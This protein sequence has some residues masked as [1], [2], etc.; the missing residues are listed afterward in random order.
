MKIKNQSAIKRRI[1]KWNDP[2][3]KNV[4]KYKIAIY[5]TNDNHV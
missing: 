3:N 2:A 4:L 1:I 5:E